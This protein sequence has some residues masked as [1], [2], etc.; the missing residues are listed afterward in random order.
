MKEKIKTYLNNYL[1]SL[2][3]SIRANYTSFSSDYFC[4]DEKNANICAKLIREKIKKA[5]CSMKYWYVEGGEDMPKVG[6]LEVVTDWYGNPSSIIETTAVSECN[7]SEVSK[8]FAYLEGEGD[9]SLEWWQKAHWEFFSKECKEV[10]IKPSK[11]MA[12]IL[13]EFKV[14]Y[15]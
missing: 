10:G 11:N 1:D 2:E 8:G 15:S 9:K 12:L 13:E 14:V 5:T 3:P 7:F 6:H 4:A